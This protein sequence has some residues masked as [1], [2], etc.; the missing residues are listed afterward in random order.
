MNVIAIVGSHGAL[1]QVPKADDLIEP[2]DQITVIGSSKA[3]DRLNEELSKP[4]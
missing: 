1:N 2:H 4:E 3:I